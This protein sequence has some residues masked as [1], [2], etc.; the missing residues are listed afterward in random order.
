MYALILSAQRKFP[1][2]FRLNLARSHLFN[3][4]RVITALDVT[5]I[6]IPPKPQPPANGWGFLLA[7]HNFNWRS[8]SFSVTFFG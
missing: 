1:H 7:S 6:H 3:R 5:A 2:N 4:Q 8:L